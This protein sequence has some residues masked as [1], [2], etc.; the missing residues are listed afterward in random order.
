MVAEI[1]AGSTLAGELRELILAR[2]ALDEG[3]SRS[4][5][6]GWQSGTEFQSWGGA[7]GRLLLDA[8]CAIANE[9][10]VVH[11]DGALVRRPIDWRI[12]SWANVNRCGDSNLRHLHPGGVWSGSFYVD[13]GG[14]GGEDRLGGAIEFCDPRG[15]L[16][17]MVAP[18]VKIAIGG[19]VSAGLRE[20]LYPKA[21]TLVMF[22]SWLEHAVAPYF[23]GG[24][25]ISVA[26]NLSI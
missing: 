25:R 3:I 17:L 15:P 11:A 12:D 2:E 7:P 20:R 6:G 16:P 1:A 5:A 13:D 4:N 19:C 24:T 21:G 14:I 26:F 18:T 22:P 23:G 9:N 10:S 8:I